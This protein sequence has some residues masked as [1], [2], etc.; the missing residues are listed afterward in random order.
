MKRRLPIILSVTALVVAVAGITPLGE[1]ARDA[2][3]VVRF[4][5]NADK[6]DGLHASR[7]P[8]AGRLLALNSSKKFPSS[9]LTATGLNGLESVTAVSAQDSSSP[10]V[11]LINCP[12]GKRAISGSARVTG[13]A[14]NNGDV[15]V[16]E[17]FPSS[18]SQWTVRAVETT[19][20]MP[21]W[22]LTGQAFCAAG[23]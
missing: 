10:K 11:V 21:S 1:A 23:T 20:V 8:K 13:T 3:Q 22:M 5:R 15:V 17:S 7:S 16:T 2:T 4:A 18:A 19:A 12:A 14:A 9:V 6:V